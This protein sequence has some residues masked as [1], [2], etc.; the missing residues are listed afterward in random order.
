[1]TTV[2]AHADYLWSVVVRLRC[3]GTPMLHQYLYSSSRAQ[4][5]VV[6]KFRDKSEL[7]QTTDLG[8]EKD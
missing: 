2:L 3:I 4:E 7:A 6:T 8:G 5:R 1:M